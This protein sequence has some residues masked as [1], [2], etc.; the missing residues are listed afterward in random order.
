MTCSCSYFISVNEQRWR[1]YQITINELAQMI[2]YINKTKK[3]EA[4]YH[5]WKSSSKPTSSHRS[6]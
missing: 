3:Y 1:W 4:K 2:R 5:K 6:A